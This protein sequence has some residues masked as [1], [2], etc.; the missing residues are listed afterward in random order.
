MDRLKIYMF[1]AVAVVAAGVIIIIVGCYFSSTGIPTID[2]IFQNPDIMHAYTSRSEFG[3]HLNMAGAVIA[4][5]GA[6]AASLVN[7]KMQG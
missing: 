2:E 7:R 3:F 5:A 6:I 1:A 4:T